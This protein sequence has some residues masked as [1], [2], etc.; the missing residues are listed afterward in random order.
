MEHESFE[1]PAIARLM[2]E[3]FVCIKVD[4]EERPDL[5]HIYMSAVQIADGPRRLADVGVSDARFA[6]VLWRHVLAAESADGHAGVRSGAVG[7][8]RCVEEPASSKR[9]S[10]RRS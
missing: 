10:M 2:N 1:N 4:R 7:R 9:S 3:N 5:D 8:G 6:A